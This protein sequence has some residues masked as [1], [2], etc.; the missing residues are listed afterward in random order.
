VDDPA[1]DGVP[2]QAFPTRP[3]HQPGRLPHRDFD[4]GRS[5]PARLGRYVRCGNPARAFG[6]IPGL[7]LGRLSL[8]V[9]TR[10]KCCRAWGWRLVACD[11]PRQLGLISL[12]GTAAAPR[13]SRPWHRP[14]EHRR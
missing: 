7:C 2:A 12:N 3:D 11:A 13:P 8:F 4:L 10:H 6:K 5:L 1:S 9:A 14:A